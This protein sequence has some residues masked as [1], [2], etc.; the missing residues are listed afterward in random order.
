MASVLTN[1]GISI[2]DICVINPEQSHFGSINNKGLF[3][4]WDTDSGELVSTLQVEGKCMIEHPCLPIIA[5]GSDSGTLHFFNIS[6]AVS[7]HFLCSFFLDHFIID[8]VLFDNS[9]IYAVAAGLNVGKFFILQMSSSSEIFYQVTHHINLEREVLSMRIISSPLQFFL[10][11]LFPLPELQ[12]SK[13]KNSKCLK[14]E[15]I[16][17]EMCDSVI[18]HD[19]LATKR[20]EIVLYRG[21]RLDNRNIWADSG[22]RNEI[23]HYATLKLQLLHTEDEF[24]ESIADE[25]TYYSDFDVI[26][27]PFLNSTVFYV[28]P[29]HSQ[30]ISIIEINTKNLEDGEAAEMT[31]EINTGHLIRCCGK[32]K[33]TIQIGSNSKSHTT[34]MTFGADGMV[35][36]YRHDIEIGLVQLV[37]VLRNHHYLNGGVRKALIIPSRSFLLSLGWDG[38]TIGNRIMPS[39]TNSRNLPCVI[40]FSLFCI[41]KNMSTTEK[42][43]LPLL[44]FDLNRKLREEKIQKAEMK[45]KEEEIKILNIIKMNKSRSEELC[46]ECWSS[47]EVKRKCIKAIKGKLEV[48]NYTLMPDKADYEENIGEVIERRVMEIEV[49]FNKLFTPWIPK[50]HRIAN[51]KKPTIVDEVETNSEHA[52]MMYLLKNLPQKQIST[53]GSS[54]SWMQLEIEEE[55]RKKR[56]ECKKEKS[57]MYMEF[58]SVKSE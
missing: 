38:C 26:G 19:I 52:S 1:F 9:G 22:K 33:K 27:G 32:G 7:P 25:R 47:M 39:I 49:T 5:M 14:E 42:M 28:L 50:S 34:L 48:E 45:R 37:N 51:H 15:N 40:L 20:Q 54:K 41:E 8:K 23:L 46:R 36:I 16:T 2:Y 12:S 24:T 30:R 58:E 21:V 6:D 31:R 57:S 55:I 53:P 43:K 11:I 44:E 29:T 13:E 35:L 10:A 56:E 4:V 3:Q 17:G 18:K